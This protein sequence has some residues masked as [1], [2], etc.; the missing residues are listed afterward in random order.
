MR[1]C[2]H[3]KRLTVNALENEQMEAAMQGWH[4][5]G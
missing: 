5:A 2:E 1:Y 4:P 3:Q